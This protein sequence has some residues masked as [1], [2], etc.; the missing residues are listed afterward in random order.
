MATAFHDKPDDVTYLEKYL[1]KRPY[2]VYDAWAAR[3]MTVMVM[4]YVRRFLEDPSNIRNPYLRSSLYVAGE[5]AVKVAE[6]ADDDPLTAG[7][8][9]AVRIFRAELA[10][11]EL[12]GLRHFDITVG[13]NA[14]GSPGRVRLESG[15]VGVAAQA[16][17]ARTVDDIAC[18]LYGHFGDFLDSYRDELSLEG[19][20]RGPLGKVTAVARE[21]AGPFYACAFSLAWVKRVTGEETEETIL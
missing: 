7:D 3:E 17:D 11:A 10:S 4:L 12:S 9:P 15:G 21:G 13:G 1:Y 6:G 20:N 2:G 16:R 5:P 8:S 18:E 14:F 19:F